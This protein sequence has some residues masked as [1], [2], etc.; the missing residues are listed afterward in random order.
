MASD[1]L[2]RWPEYVYSTEERWN[3]AASGARGERQVAALGDKVGTAERL[4]AAGVPT[5][6]SLIVPPLAPSTDWEAMARRW[7]SRWPWV[8]VKRRRGSRGT[9]AFELRSRDDGSMSLRQFQHDADE[10]D[11]A[12]WLAVSVA[13]HELLVQPRLRSHALFEYVADPTDVVTIRAVTRDL[14]RGPA[15]FCAASA[16]E[17]CASP[18]A[19]R[20]CVLLWGYVHDGGGRGV[21]GR[22]RWLG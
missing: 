22:F 21:R 6:P 7:L 16:E 13:G 9:G 14:G 4:A 18:C 15:L 1:G 8:H 10:A 17:L 20:T 12:A 3:A 11:P 2:Q 5:V 19:I